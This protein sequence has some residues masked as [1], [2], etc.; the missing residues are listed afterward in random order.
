MA[1]VPQAPQNEPPVPI[2]NGANQRWLRLRLLP[3][4][5]RNKASWHT[6]CSVFAVVHRQLAG[7]G[8][9]LIPSEQLP[10]GNVRLPRFLEAILEPAFSL[11][12]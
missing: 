11:Q 2:S 9:G 8:R 12:A 7:A 10:G 1:A 4:P 3:V 6:N 5:F